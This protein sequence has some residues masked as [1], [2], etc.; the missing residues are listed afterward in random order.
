[1]V[2]EDF[3]ALRR[4]R[5]DRRRR[6]VGTSRMCRRVERLRGATFVTVSG[7]EQRTLTRRS[8]MG[9]QFSLVLVMAA[10]AVT[11]CVSQNQ[12]LNNMQPMAVQNAENRGRFELNCPNAT[13]TVLSREV[14]QP[15]LEGPF[16]GAGLQRAEYTVGVA[17]CGPRKTFV[18]ISP[19][20]G[21]RCLSS[22]SRRFLR[23]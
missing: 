19:D 12:F 16:V 20:A 4:T 23:D 13:A 15:V 5:R 7:F 10:V 11:G 3:R 2:S 1:M 9:R 6:M 18:L 22:R 17:G 14:V 8:S 21:D